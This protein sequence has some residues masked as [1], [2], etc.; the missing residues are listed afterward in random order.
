[1][2]LYFPD[3]AGISLLDRTKTHTS[4]I[5]PGKISLIAMTSF[6]S[7]EVR[8]HSSVNRANDDSDALLNHSRV[9]V[10]NVHR[11][12]SIVSFDRRCQI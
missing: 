7:S 4:D 3:I 10:A 5:L 9:V 11:S 8:L 1:M 12:I 2:A 6:K